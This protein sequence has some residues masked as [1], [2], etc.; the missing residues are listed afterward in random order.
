M[1]QLR[2][3][4]R[5]TKIFRSHMSPRLVAQSTKSQN[6]RV[7]LGFIIAYVYILPVHLVQGT[8]FRQ[9]QLEMSH[10]SALTETWVNEQEKLGYTKLIISGATTDCVHFG[11]GQPGLR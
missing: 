4:H 6:S 10:D 7:S 8:R 3:S 9:S 2:A 1:F 11:T 5:P